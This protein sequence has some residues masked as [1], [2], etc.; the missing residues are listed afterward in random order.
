MT[1]NKQ[2]IIISGCYV[3]RKLTFYMVMMEF[4]AKYTL[5]F[6]HFSFFFLMILNQGLQRLKKLN[7]R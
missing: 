4:A 5:A 1:E 6:I 2:E 3:L 7:T